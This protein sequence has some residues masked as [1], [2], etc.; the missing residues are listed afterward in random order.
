MLVNENGPFITLEQLGIWSTQT[1]QVQWESSRVA[2]ELESII[3]AAKLKNYVSS[4]RSRHDYHNFAERSVS[5]HISEGWRDLNVNGPLFQE[6]LWLI[7]QTWPKD[8]TPVEYLMRYAIKCKTDFPG[9]KDYD[10]GR[11]I[12]NLPSFLREYFIHSALVERGVSA[13]VPSPAENAS[14]HSDLY[15]STE[16]GQVGMWSFQST[17][18]GFEMLRRKIQF[19]A[20]RFAEINFL[21]PF[22]SE[23]DS[24][25]FNG[26][27]IPS[28][29]YMDSIVNRLNRVDLSNVEE[30]RSW[31]NGGH[32]ESNFMMVSGQ[33]IEKY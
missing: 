14:G 33:E 31:M 9:Q 24:E 27:Y 18:K 17:N 8:W 4:L 10:I 28:S 16:N 6:A 5:G 7:M 15:I 32:V 23:I 26:W 13:S 20:S 19:R 30:L 21:C 1:W 12:R 11:A 3:D 2:S 22:R 25:D 29:E